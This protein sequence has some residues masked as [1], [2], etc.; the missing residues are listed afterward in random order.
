MN[1][2]AVMHPAPISVTPKHDLKQAMHLMR[3]HN[4]RHLPVQDGSDLVG[5]VTERDIDFAL[6]FEH[7]VPEKMLVR[8]AYL[9]DPYTVDCSTPVATVAAKMAEEHIGCA[10]VVKNGSLAGIFT[11]VDACRVLADVLNA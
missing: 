9:P 8:D 4:I 6:R 3:D 11:T 7:T 5:I 10:L 1:I 2:E